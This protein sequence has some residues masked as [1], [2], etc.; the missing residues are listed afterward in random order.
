MALILVHVFN[1][2]ISR[3]S[4]SLKQILSKI[5]QY[6]FFL[7]VVSGKSKSLTEILGWRRGELGCRA[8]IPSS[9]SGTQKGSRPSAQIDVP[10]MM[11]STQQPVNFL[12]PPTHPSAHRTGF[13]LPRRDP[14]QSSQILRGRF[15]QQLPSPSSL[16]I[17]QGCGAAGEARPASAFGEEAFKGASPRVRG[18]SACCCTV[19][20]MHLCMCV[21]DYGRLPSSTLD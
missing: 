1:P 12:S 18:I 6:F 19:V 11:C 2:L 10:F 15:L 17:S 9:H 13:S 20:R 14:T 5:D 8:A 7:S 4:E 3:Y 21:G 16:H